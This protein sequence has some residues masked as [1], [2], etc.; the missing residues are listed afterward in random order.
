M[1]VISISKNIL[2]QNINIHNA[3]LFIAPNYQFSIY[4]FKFCF[5]KLNKIHNDKYQAEFD[6]RRFCA[7]C[8]RYYF[9][10]KF[11]SYK[12][13]KNIPSIKYSINNNKAWKKHVK[14]LK[15]EEKLKV[16]K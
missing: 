6:K 7:T 1:K 14:Y 4:D 10:G 16:F 3:I 12:L 13:S 15:H 5:I 9:H 8:K 11:I 2:Y